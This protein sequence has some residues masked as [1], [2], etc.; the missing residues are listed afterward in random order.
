MSRQYS[1]PENHVTRMGS[2]GVPMDSSDSDSDAKTSSKI[3]NI[4]E[5]VD[6]YGGTVVTCNSCRGDVPGKSN[7][8]HNDE[9]DFCMGCIFKHQR[10]ESCVT[11]IP[12]E[13]A[14]EVCTDIT[15]CESCINRF[16]ETLDWTRLREVFDIYIIY[17]LILWQWRNVTNMTIEGVIH[18]NL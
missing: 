6:V 5:A 16:K 14:T 1:E 18:A 13:R 3:W 12:G 17:K 9:T 2:R 11:R 7:V 15:P 4:F 10:N 8:L